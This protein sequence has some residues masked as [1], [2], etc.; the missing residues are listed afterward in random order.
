MLIQHNRSFT[1]GYI[2]MNNVRRAKKNQ[3]EIYLG[4]C[5]DYFCV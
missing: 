2:Y 5:Q 1:D 4:D 3:K